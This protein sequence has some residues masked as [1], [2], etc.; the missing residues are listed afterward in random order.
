ME[1]IKFPTFTIPTLK[2]CS[3]LLTFDEIEA[4]L[5][6]KPH[7]VQVGLGELQKANNLVGLNLNWL[8]SPKD[9]PILASGFNP[10]IPFSIQTF[11][12]DSEKKEMQFSTSTARTS[13]SY[14]SMVQLASQMK[15]PSISI[16]SLPCEEAEEGV[17]DSKKKSARRNLS[18]SESLTAV[19]PNLKF[20]VPLTGPNQQLQLINDPNI[21][22]LTGPLK[23]LQDFPEIMKE[24][25]LIKFARIPND[26]EPRQ[27][28]NHVQE[29][30]SSGADVI[31]S[32]LPFRFAKLGLLLE[33]NGTIL[34]MKDSSMFSDS[35]P[36]VYQLPS[37]APLCVKEAAQYF[38]SYVHHL[39]RCDELA[40]PILLA[41][42]NL[43]IFN[44]LFTTA[45]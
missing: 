32:D 36:L 38:R 34:D 10:G 26:L 21:I 18:F 17:S 7:L 31:E 42:V 9:W 16:V 25:K 3:I 23:R 5:Q 39:F 22:G 20:V 27:M 30:L 1:R 44:C 11:L 37:S 12:F 19:T 8:F 45:E 28:L 24:K 6:G 2:C 43:Y 4:I 29:A 35:N 15:N 33:S 14:P 40:G 41:T 13:L